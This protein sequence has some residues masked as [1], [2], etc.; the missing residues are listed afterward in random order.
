M[1]EARIDLTEE[2]RAV[3]ESGSNRLAVRAA[4]GSGKTRVLVE[5]YL[6]L[7]LE[8]GLGPDQLLTI[9]YTRKAAAEMKRRIVAGLKAAGKRQMAAQAESGPIQTIHGFCERLL[10]ENAPAAGLDPEFK[11]LS[12]AE[13]KI[14]LHEALR[15]ALAY[16]THDDPAV[17]RLL[18]VLAGERQWGQT[19]PH[20]KLM[21]ECERCLEA[22]RSN[23]LD[24]ER[25]AELY[26]SAETTLAHWNRVVLETLPSGARAACQAFVE[27]DLFLSKAKAAGQTPAWLN[28]LQPA[29]NEEAAIHTAGMMHLVL[30]AWQL[31]EERQ[32]RRQELDYAALEARGVLLVERRAAVAD[33]IRRQYPV[34][35]VDEAQDMNP[36]QHRLLDAIGAASEM[37]VGDAQQ[38]IFGF[39]HA[40][41]A[42][43]VSKTRDREALALTHNFRSDEGILRF[44][45]RYFQ[46]KF[47]SDY[48]R[49]TPPQELDLD[50]EG[51]EK[52]PGVEFW[53]C[54]KGDWH[55]VA[56]NIAAMIADGCKPGDMAVLVQKWGSGEGVLRALQAMQI[57]ARIAG[58]AS[59]FYTRLDVRDLSNAL[60]ALAN[61]Y[62]DFALI[63][64]LLS[65]VCGVSLDSAALLA[66][67]RPVVQA[68]TDF[69]PP[70]ESDLAP[71]AAFRD[72]FLRLQATADRLSASEALGEV[73]AGTPYLQNLARREGADQRLANVRKLQRLAAESLEMD[74]GQFAET[75]REVRALRHRE[76]D[77]PALDESEDAVTILSVHKA[78]GLEFDV[79][80]LADLRSSRQKPADSTLVLPREEMIVVKL[81]AHRSNYFAF[82]LERK[83]VQEALEE[84]RVFYVAATRARKKLC[85][86]LPEGAVA[87]S[88]ADELRSM[89]RFGI[90]E[91]RPQ[92]PVQ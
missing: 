4:A 27:T 76:G 1:S 42:L 59:S 75:M 69:E 83:A 61:P 72:W 91:R 25:L 71:F 56:R 51:P 55:A 77:A 37:L 70:L 87:G 90:E 67:R 44:V 33:R 32:F 7:V 58:A 68:L 35:M 30:R 11:I 74:A 80:V 15:Q 34:V 10:R 84:T 26:A 43:F 39:R 13:Q 81:G 22:V 48:L 36:V 78:K 49:M 62:D 45:D 79:A 38:S 17:E 6:R 88:P 85:I 20:S 92:A 65:P 40:D 63:A 73:F 16:E 18:Q 14:A 57:P 89:F 28:Q 8:Q 66:L 53:P 19:E 9:T 86:V 82:A 23:G 24:M 3:V 54:D 47:E 2:Q 52:F 50:A 64:T 29:L 46:R 5:R 21:S 41:A 31:L 60:A 12:D